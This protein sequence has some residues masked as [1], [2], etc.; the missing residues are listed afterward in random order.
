MASQTR[1]A[2]AVGLLCLSVG[3]ASTAELARINAKYD[4]ARANFDCDHADRLNDSE[5]WLKCIYVERSR[6]YEL[7]RARSPVNTWLSDHMTG[8]GLI[9]VP[10]VVY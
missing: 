9:P 8:G 7:D 5:T 1:V 3:C 2:V 6:A 10:V 4:Q